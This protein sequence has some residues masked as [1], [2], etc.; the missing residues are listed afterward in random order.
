LAEIIPYG[1]RC[2]GCGKLSPR[3]QTCSACRSHN[4][5]NFV[6]VST[7]YE[8]TARDLVQR[9]KFHHQRAAA[10]AIG[11]VMNSTF[12]Y[13]NPAWL[14]QKKNY[15]IISLPT[16]TSRIRQ[17]GFDHTALIAT[18]VSRQLKIENKNL[19]QR[20]G[21]SRQVGAKRYLRRRQ[22]K[23]MFYVSAPE[24]LKG[25]NILLID[26]V[27]TTGATLQEAAKTLRRAGAR[28]VDA[29]VF[30]KKL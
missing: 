12:L 15:L 6:W 29:L 16:A 9:L 2:F 22:L 1:E 10:N 30:A 17:R 5:P 3:S 19:L 24:A 20:L 4:S 25:R 8:T 13:F 27:V 7:D 11:Q 26:D 14:V 21:Q 28:S 18:K 23:D